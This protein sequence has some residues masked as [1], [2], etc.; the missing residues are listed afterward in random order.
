M[1][2]VF[3]RINELKD[4]LERFQ[5]LVHDCASSG[6]T[7]SQP[8]DWWDETYAVMEELQS[9]ERRS[10]LYPHVQRLID[11]TE[12]SIGEIDRR[13][14]SQRESTPPTEIPFLS[15]TDFDRLEFSISET[16]A[17][18]EQLEDDVVLV[19]Q[20]VD[21]GPRVGN[22]SFLMNAL[23]VTL[24][25]ISQAVAG[26]LLEVPLAAFFWS[27]A[28]GFASILFIIDLH[29]VIQERPWWLYGFSE[30][31]LFRKMMNSPS[32]YLL[33]I[34]PLTLAITSGILL[35]GS[36][37]SVLTAVGEASSALLIALIIGS[38]TSFIHFNKWRNRQYL[39]C[40]W[41]GKPTDNR[42]ALDVHCEQEHGWS[43]P[44][45]VSNFRSIIEEIQTD[46]I[47]EPPRSGARF[48]L[49]SL[50]WFAAIE[51]TFFLKYGDPTA[52]VMLLIADIFLAIWEWGAI[53]PRES[54]SH[55]LASEETSEKARRTA[56]SWLARILF[57][58]LGLK[59]SVGIVLTYIILILVGSPIAELVAVF[60]TMNGGVYL[61]FVVLLSRRGVKGILRNLHSWER[62]YSK[63]K[64]IA[65]LLAAYLFSL[66]S[67]LLAVASGLQ[68][69]YI[70]LMTGLPANVMALLWSNV[71]YDEISLQISENMTSS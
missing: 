43:V 39:L 63:E 7:D 36:I 59:Y 14:I 26:H 25:L 19:E 70:F 49:H 13:T 15:R 1:E 57:G 30:G 11:I 71:L 3:H 67:G 69:G 52:F 40:P 60:M 31:G 33:L 66:I 65:W 62:V 47:L 48:L 28:S 24:F 10:V 50:L 64:T 21:I 58:Y 46:E 9:I 22:P 34:L 5:E 38:I 42:S 68:I 27:V 44:E 54:G 16:T 2:D 32:F 61:A 55:I 41:C 29:N 17:F 20:A 8:Q 45:G 6:D 18:M 53:F 35:A 23:M 37:W 51:Y 4:A 56:L 12:S